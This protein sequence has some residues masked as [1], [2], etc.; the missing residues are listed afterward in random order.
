MVA[1]SGAGNIIRSIQAGNELRGDNFTDLSE[2][3]VAHIRFI[4]F[5]FTAS[6]GNNAF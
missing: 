4:A 2:E 6:Y 3:K 1:I 5:F